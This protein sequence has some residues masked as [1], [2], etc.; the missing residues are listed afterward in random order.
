M[1]VPYHAIDS[2]LVLIN[3]PNRQACQK[4]LAD[5]RSLFQTVWGSVH[6]HQAW[7][8]GYHDHVQEI[9]NVAKVLYE[10]LYACRP[11]PFTL[12]DTLLIVFLHDLEKPWKYEPDGAGGIREIAELRDKNAQKAFREKRLAEYGITLTEDQRNALTYVEG[13]SADYSNRRRVAG[14]L[15]ALCHLA[16][17]TSA[18][19]WFNF[20]LT[21]ASDDFWG[22]TRDRSA[23]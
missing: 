9:M 15:A 21:H 11:L 16:D 12:S 5:N 14:P 23:P 8:G 7:E 19:I 1:P 6:N 2:L 17:F 20:P 4:L 13:E 22:A 18:R 10:T 3:G